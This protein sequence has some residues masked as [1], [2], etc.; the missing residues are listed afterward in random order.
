MW[1]TFLY[2]CMSWITGTI[3]VLYTLISVGAGNSIQTS[4][5]G[6]C[7]VLLRYSHLTDLVI[8]G[9]TKSCNN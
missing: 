9:K 6:Q 8:P 3:A 7:C 2:K 1:D 4:L 5:T